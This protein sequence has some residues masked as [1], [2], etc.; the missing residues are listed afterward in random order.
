M[1]SEKLLFIA[2]NIAIAMIVPDCDG[3]ARCRS[4]RDRA[5]QLQPNASDGA[6]P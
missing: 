4:A 6:D 1:R 2:S 5:A 3:E